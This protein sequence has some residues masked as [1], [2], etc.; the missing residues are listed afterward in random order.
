[1]RGRVCATIALLILFP[2]VSGRC[3]STY[4]TAELETE[5]GWGSRHTHTHRSSVPGLDGEQE[6]CQREVLQNAVGPEQTHGQQSLDG[7][8]SYLEGS[9]PTDRKLWVDFLILSTANRGQFWRSVHPPSRIYP[10]KRPRR[11]TVPVH[12]RSWL[13]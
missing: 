1:M 10:S 2:V 13:F 6:H 12:F 5:S 3:R 7:H 11:H 9:L 8:H 4:T